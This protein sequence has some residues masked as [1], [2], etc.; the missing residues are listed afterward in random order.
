MRIWHLVANM[1]IDGQ[2]GAC[3]DRLQES[4]A[5]LGPPDQEEWANSVERCFSVLTCN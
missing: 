5:Y 1:V 4:R 2:R 3:A